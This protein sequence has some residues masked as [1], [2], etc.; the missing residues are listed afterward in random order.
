MPITPDGAFGTL[1]I[2]GTRMIS[3]TSMMGMPYSSFAR[4][5]VIRCSLS[6]SAVR[7]AA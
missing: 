3:W 7:V 5:K 2:S 1:V 4:R 6:S